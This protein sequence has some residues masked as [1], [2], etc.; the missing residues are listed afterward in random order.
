MI[1]LIYGSAILAVAI[2]GW[3]IGFTMGRRDGC[4]GCKELDALWEQSL[5]LS[6]VVERQRCRCRRTTS[7][8]RIL[9]DRCWAL[10][11]AEGAR[12]GEVL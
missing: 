9:C 11:R 6:E 4:K 2:L 12:Q 1:G 7:G 8:D 5:A 10:R 3:S